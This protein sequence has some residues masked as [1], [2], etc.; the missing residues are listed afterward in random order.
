MT[1]NLLRYFL[2]NGITTSDV[3]LNS[4][5]AVAL[6]AIILSMWRMHKGNGIYRNFNLVFLIVNA[7]GYPD[8]AKCVE[9]GV[10]LLMS[11]G[12]VV[13]MTKGSLSEWYLV[14]YVGAFVTRGAFGAYLRSKS[15]PD[16]PG[17]TV[18]TTTETMVKSKDVQTTDQE[19]RPTP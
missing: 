4:L 14:A 3:I 5:L 12:F 11:W 18:I 7:Q 1:D 9:L 19:T 13:Q 2:M 15:A 6:G 17:T 10:F 8:G 16:V